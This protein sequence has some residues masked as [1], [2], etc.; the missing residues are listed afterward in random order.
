MAYVDFLFLDI[1][2]SPNEKNHW[3]QRFHNVFYIKISYK[4]CVFAWLVIY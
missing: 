3:I 4:L 1:W 2:V